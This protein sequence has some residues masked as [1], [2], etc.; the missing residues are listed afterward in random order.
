MPRSYVRLTLLSSLLAILLSAALNYIVDPYGV[1][2]FIDREGFN[3]HKPKMGVN[4]KLAKPYNVQRVQP[5]TLLLG[6]SR[7]E[8]GIDPESPHWPK[9]SLPVYNMAL[10]GTGIGTAFDS[11]RYVMSVAKPH[12]AVVGVDFFDFLVDERPTTTKPAVPAASSDLNGML[13]ANSKGL[14]NAFYPL[15][16]IKDLASTLFS[17]NALVDSALTLALQSRNDQPDL[18]DRGFNP[19]REYERFARVDGYQTLFRQVETNYFTNYIRG[20]KSIYSGGGTTSVELDQLRQ[21]I[22]LCRASSIKLLLYI[23]PYHAHMLEGYRIAGLWPSFEEWKR[24]LVKILAEDATAHP[25]T[26]PLEL[27]DFSGYNEITIERVPTQSEKGRMMRWYWDPGH[28]K[29]E[30]G[31][32]VLARMLESSS[33]DGPAPAAFGTKL[34]EQNIDS[35]L[36]AISA[37]QR[38]YEAARR[39]EVATLE[40]LAQSIRART[41]RAR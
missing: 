39:D 20:P 17:L 36:K 25:G 34:N 26:A 5:G 7:V 35:H 18:T 28:Y 38:Q 15:Q 13:P 11:L 3:R 4:S 10:P 24:A 41:N 33:D 1:Y 2:R 21:L 22:N 30:A 40:D 32:F 27:W 6:N 37:G 16:K 29:R 9:T 12:T 14:Y 23:H 8:V 19:M 31:E